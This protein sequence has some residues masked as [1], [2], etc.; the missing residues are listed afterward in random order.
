MSQSISLRPIVWEKVE[1]AYTIGRE[2]ELEIRLN[3][4]N[5]NK[6]NVST[7]GK[8]H[9]VAYLHVR[10]QPPVGVEWPR[11]NGKGADTDTGMPTLVFLLFVWGKPE[12][13]G[14]TEMRHSG[15]ETCSVISDVEDCT[16]EPEEEQDY[17]KP[18]DHVLR[19]RNVRGYSLDSDD[20]DECCSEEG[21]TPFD[22]GSTTSL[23]PPSYSP[24]S[25]S[26]QPP[27]FPGSETYA[28]RHP[29]STFVGWVA[30]S[31]LPQYTEK[32]EVPDDM[33]FA[34]RFLSSFTCYRELRDATVESDYGAVYVRLQMEWTYTG[35]LVGVFVILLPK[36]LKAN[37]F[38]LR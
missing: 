16:S 17:K 4:Q 34:E 28:I 31:L 12:T 23:F 8:S 15:S 14:C 21:I 6:K 20:D 13:F 33:N 3:C 11:S 38:G 29:P 1:Y 27:F 36:R 22:D 19:H 30:A 9:N 7:R 25:P 37:W 2:T 26:S 10:L 35:G 24:P 5:S 32:V 18:I